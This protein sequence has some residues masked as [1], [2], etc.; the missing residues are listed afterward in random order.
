MAFC[1]C[2]SCWRM[3]GLR[4]GRLLFAF[5]SSWASLGENKERSVRKRDE[6]EKESE[7]DQEIEEEG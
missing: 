6:I 7:I 5:C 4:L 1:S 3:M 2:S